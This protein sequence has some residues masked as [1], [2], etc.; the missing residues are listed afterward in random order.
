MLS[1]LAV[2]ALSAAQPIDDPFVIEEP[3]P[4]PEAQAPAAAAPASAAAA[5]PSPHRLICR[6]RPALGSR[7]VSRRLCKTSEE[8]VTY[9]NDLEMSRRDIADRGASGCDPG[10]SPSCFPNGGTSGPW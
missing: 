5:E 2:M 8:W 4:A 1:F 9:E 6:S 3:A 10:N 7:L